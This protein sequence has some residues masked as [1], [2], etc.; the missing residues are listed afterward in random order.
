MM[1]A[2]LV[3]RLKKKVNVCISK[4]NCVVFPL[5]LSKYFLLLALCY[6]MELVIYRQHIFFRGNFFINNNCANCVSAHSYA[7]SLVNAVFC[8]KFIFVFIF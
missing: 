1:A 7:S 5:G 4:K 6:I 3:E 2:Q 8:S